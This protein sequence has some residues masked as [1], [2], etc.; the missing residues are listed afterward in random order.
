MAVWIKGDISLNKPL[1]FEHPT[2]DVVI[3]G[4]LT[5]DFDISFIVRNLVVFGEI[6][7]T[8][9]VA[10]NTAADFFKFGFIKGK[11][12]SVVSDANTYL[13]AND[14]AIEKIRALGIDLTRTPGG[15]LSV[16]IPN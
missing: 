7:T 8:K 11:E 4:K 2:K 16:R 10:L 14:E 15:G 3:S 9:D 1:V 13:G 6:V 5:S 12:V